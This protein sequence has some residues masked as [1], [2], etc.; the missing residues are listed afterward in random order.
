[1]KYE[2]TARMTLKSS[3]DADRVAK[4]TESVFDFGTVSEAIAEGLKLGEDPHLVEVSVRSR[5]R[6]RAPQT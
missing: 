4:Q 5:T 3:C 1:M 6:E 2:V